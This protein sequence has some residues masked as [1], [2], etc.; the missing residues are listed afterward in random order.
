MN[1]LTVAQLIKVLQAVKNQSLPVE[2]EGC[3]C[4]GKAVDVEENRREVFITRQ[5][6]PNGLRKRAL[7][8]TIPYVAPCWIKGALGG[9]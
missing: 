2:T 1:R 7:E 5:I 6:E 8:T 3:D 4:F 9:Y